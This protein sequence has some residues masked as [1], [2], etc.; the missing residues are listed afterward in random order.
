MWRGEAVFR[1]KAIQASDTRP[2]VLRNNG[3]WL[4]TAIASLMFQSAYSIYLHKNHYIPTLRGDNLSWKSIFMKAPNEQ[5]SWSRP[6]R[7][8]IIWNR[9]KSNVTTMAAIYEVEWISIT[10]SSHGGQ[11]LKRELPLI[12]GAFECGTRIYG[13]SRTM[14]IYGKFNE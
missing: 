12:C 2:T 5:F 7:L 11:L 4:H 14:Q 9:L 3:N 13:D 6:H 8:W 10:M 1:H